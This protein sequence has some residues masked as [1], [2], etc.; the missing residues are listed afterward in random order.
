V[1]A[2]GKGTPGVT[3]EL[4][5]EELLAAELTAEALAMELDWGGKYRQRKSEFS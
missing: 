5:A 4:A 3:T 2:K 1:A